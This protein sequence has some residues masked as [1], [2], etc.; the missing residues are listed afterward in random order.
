MTRYRI[1]KRKTFWENFREGA[2]YLC[3]FDFKNDLDWRG[4]EGS[5]WSYFLIFRDSTLDLAIE[6]AKQYNG[7]I[8]SISEKDLSQL[9][10]IR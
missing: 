5:Y 4:A 1:K 3:G 6:L 10:D 7:E 8:V 9:V 2:E